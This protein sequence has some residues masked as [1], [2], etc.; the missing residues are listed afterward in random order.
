[1]RDVSLYR[2]KAST[3]LAG[4]F[5]WIVRLGYEVDSAEV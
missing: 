3:L 1:M 4:E 5:I 2:I